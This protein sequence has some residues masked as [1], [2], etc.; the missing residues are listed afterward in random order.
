[1]TTIEQ[2]KA[3]EILDSRGRLTVQATCLLSDCT[4]VTTSV[5]SSKST[6]KAEAFELRYGDPKRYNGLGCRKAVQNVNTT[7]NEMIKGRS[8]LSQF[9]FDH[10]LFSLDG[11]E[12]KHLLGANAILLAPDSESA[13]SDTHHCIP[14]VPP[15]RKRCHLQSD[16]ERRLTLMAQIERDWQCHWEAHDLVL[17]LPVPARLL[18]DSQT[19]HPAPV[20]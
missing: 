11:T 15:P 16:T 13:T 4:S 14:V 12:N 2:V 7:I 5:P 9:D 17:L 3:I 10:A 18:R 8:Y 20:P 1:M 19:Y 6:A